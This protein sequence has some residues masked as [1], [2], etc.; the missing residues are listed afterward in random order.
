MAGANRYCSLPTSASEYDLPSGPIPPSVSTLPPPD[1]FAFSTTLRKATNPDDPYAAGSSLAGADPSSYPPFASPPRPN[2][3]THKPNASDASYRRATSIDFH[4]NTANAPSSNSQPRSASAHYTHLTVQQTLEALHCPSLTNGLSPLLVHEARR[5]AGGYN[6]FAVRAGD[7]PWRKFLAQFQEPLILLLLGSAAVSLLIGQIDDAV[8]ITI[9]II[10][11]ISVAF[12][13]EQKSEKSLEALNK[14]VP[15]YCHLIRDGVTSSV[16]ANELVPG[17]VVTFSTGDRIPADV[18]VAE[19]VSLEV[20]ESTLTG[21]IKPRRKHA[22]VVPR[23]FASNGS[24]LANS[25]GSVE[26]S[27]VERES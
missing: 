27:S 15:H 18:R 4:H 25:N 17:D 14:L 22:E 10:I 26:G 5:E 8:S 6:E 21:E 13:Q 3:A 7:D 19:C 20:D 2:G 16:L 12:Y 24:G 11:V 1:Q 23:P 9:A